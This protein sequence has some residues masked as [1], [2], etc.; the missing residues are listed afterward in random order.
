MTTISQINIA[1]ELTWCEWVGFEGHQAVATYRMVFN[2]QK[3]AD[4]VAK[5]AKTRAI[6]GTVTISKIPAPDGEWIP[7]TQT[8]QGE[9]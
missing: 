3:A 4:R 6:D 2:S 8:N 7:M 1:Y 9:S 5:I